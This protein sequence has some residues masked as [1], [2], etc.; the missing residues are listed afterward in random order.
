MKAKSG[1]VTLV[2]LLLFAACAP[3]LQQNISNP[4]MVGRLQEGVTTQNEVLQMFGDPDTRSSST[5]GDMWIYNIT[6]DRKLTFGQSVASVL[7]SANPADLYSLTL[8]FDKSGVLKYKD[9]T[10]TGYLR[11][12]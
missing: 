3:S 11:K 10:Q 12:L 2:F 7:I 4:D 1:L 9:I 5:S 6:K 8:A